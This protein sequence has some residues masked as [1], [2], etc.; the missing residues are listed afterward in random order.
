MCLLVLGPGIVCWINMIEL[1]KWHVINFLNFLYLSDCEHNLPIIWSRSRSSDHRR[2]CVMVVC[3]CALFGPGQSVTQRHFGAGWNL[4]DSK[5]GRQPN[6]QN[7][8]AS[9][10]AYW[11]VGLP[12]GASPWAGQ[13]GEKAR[14]QTRCCPADASWWTTRA[15]SSPLAG[16]PSAWWWCA[17]TPTWTSPEMPEFE[18][19]PRIRPYP[20]RSPCCLFLLQVN[21]T[22]IG[23]SE[24]IL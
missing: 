22:F 18:W 16:G 7:W 14:R 4:A 8:D 17:T 11:D 19:P 2:N 24:N 9:S 1:Q 3:H 15:T 10:P 23:L 12:Q 5:I 20:P 21:S 13:K 6:L